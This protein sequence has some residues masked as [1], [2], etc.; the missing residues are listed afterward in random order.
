MI[1]GA[2][3]FALILAAVRVGY[4][5]A[6]NFSMRSPQDVFPFLLHLDTELLNG[7]FHPEA[8]EHF[9]NIHSQTNSGRCN[10]S[11]FT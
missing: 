1:T 11:A 3:I 6:T 7:A 5:L 4:R 2:L 9:R 8:E 10:G